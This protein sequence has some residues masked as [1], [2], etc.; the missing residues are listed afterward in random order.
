M[1][2][3]IWIMHTGFDLGENPITQKLQDNLQEVGQL[4]NN[5][6]SRFFKCQHFPNHITCMNT[7]YSIHYIKQFNYTE[8]I[9][10]LHLHLKIFKKTAVAWG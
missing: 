10:Y 6:T 8:R 1:Q 9:D 7:V 5:K 2:I 3:Q 4:Q